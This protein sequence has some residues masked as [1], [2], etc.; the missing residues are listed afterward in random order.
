MNTARRSN[1]FLLELVLC[2]TIFVLCAAVCTALLVRA[3]GLSRESEQ[4]TQGVYLAQSAA[5]ALR[6]GA[7]L[8]QAPQ[9]YGLDV[10]TGGPEGGVYTASITV[11]CQGET[12]YTLDTA[13]PEVSEP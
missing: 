13:W 4:L 1:L 6:S 5:E 9:G 2:L 12:V 3:R 10:R 7:P 11:T 8:P